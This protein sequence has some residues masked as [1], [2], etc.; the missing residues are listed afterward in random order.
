MNKGFI[1]LAIAIY[2]CSLF[3]KVN[4]QDSTFV[5]SIVKELSSPKYGGRGYLDSGL[6]KSSKKIQNYLTTFGYLDGSDFTPSE[7][8]IRPSFSTQNFS[9]N[10]NTFI[11]TIKMDID[12]KEK[13]AGIHF[14]MNPNSKGIK[15]V[16]KHF[17]TLSD[18][19]KIS[20][21]KTSCDVL[22]LG[23][24]YA[25]NEERKELAIKNYN[26][27]LVIILADKLTYSVGKKVKEYCEITYL[28]SNKSFTSGITLN[29]KDSNLSPML[30]CDNTFIELH[31]NRLNSPISDY[32]SDNNVNSVLYDP[33]AAIYVSNT[34]KLAQ[35]ATSLKV[36]LSGYR[37]SSSEFR[38]LYSLIRPDS[39]EVQPTFELFPG[40]DNLNTDT[41]GDGYPD[42]V[43]D[44]SK[45]D[46]KPDVFVP[47]SVNDE[48]LEY[49]YTA[50]NLGQFSGYTIKIVM[51]GTDQAH[52]PRIK[53]LRSI[54]IR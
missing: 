6:A 10:V 24:E 18:S 40:Y 43:T 4:G 3:N 28:N 25:S 36:I 42:N 1:V 32:A 35:N 46:G 7:K 17:I 15:L 33:H 51:S 31:S 11:G 53:D 29:T 9:F 37:H 45:N 12:G 23:T 52:A 48:F 16:G 19:K 49:Q 54:A 20:L 27:K 22:I 5:R 39:S 21:T 47:S 13:Y 38:V 14:I 44:P 2:W 8:E 50:N 34:V 41:N 26:P 30:F